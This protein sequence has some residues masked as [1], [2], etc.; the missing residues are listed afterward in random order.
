MSISSVEELTWNSSLALWH[1]DRPVNECRHMWEG[2]GGI[3]ENAEPVLVAAGRVLAWWGHQLLEA[4][5]HGSRLAAVVRV[6][7]VH[8]GPG[9]QME[10]VR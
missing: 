9:L 3:V 1:Q 4:G 8:E 10:S 6:V 2:V 7:E 5:C